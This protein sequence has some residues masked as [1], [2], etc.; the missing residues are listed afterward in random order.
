MIGIPLPVLEIWLH[1]VQAWCWTMVQERCVGQWNHLRGRRFTDLVSSGQGKG[2][3]P[4]FNVRTARSR[5]AATKRACDCHSDAI[6]NVR[7]IASGL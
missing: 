5:T 1:T 6:N 4:Y 3:E 2:S 7:C